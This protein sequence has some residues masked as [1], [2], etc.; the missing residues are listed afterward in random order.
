MNG[1]LT[2]GRPVGLALVLALALT[3]FSVAT[4][5]GRQAE[6]SSSA[7]CFGAASMNRE[8]ACVNPR[9]RLTVR[10]T[11]E[12][13]LLAPDAPCSPVATTPAVPQFC[14]FGTRPA[15]A[16]GS[17]ALLGD[18]HASHW[19][20]T[21]D[22]VARSKR[23]VGVSLARAGCPYT[24]LVLTASEP[25]RTKCAPW[26]ESVAAWFTAHPEV[27]TVLISAHAGTNFPVPAGQ[28]LFEAKVRGARQ[29]IERLPASV[30]NVVILRDTPI[31]TV[32]TKDCVDRAIARR[33]PAGPACRRSRRGS[34]RPDSLATA[35]KRMRSPRVRVV[36]LSSFMCGARSCLPVVGG[37]LVHKD[38]H[39]LTATFARTLGPYL[40][41]DL[42]RLKVPLG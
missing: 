33:K 34:L 7:R 35:A 32:A 3:A 2:R 12:D 13:A 40:R 15:A 20:A 42:T 14:V 4:G 8:K 38:T 16:V 41:R 24:T 19:R 10:P 37:V 21:V 36:D 39:H 1:V 18:S 5:L 29:A 26:F 23:L 6:A 30:K 11:P 9:L 17:I 25:V 22:Q 28:N 27:S 31:I